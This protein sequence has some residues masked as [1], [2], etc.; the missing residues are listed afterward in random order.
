MLHIS[1]DWQIEVKDIEM[2]STNDAVRWTAVEWWMGE[3]TARNFT[4]NRYGEGVWMWSES[5]RDWK[6]ISGTAQFSL[7]KRDT[8]LKNRRAAVKRRIEK[9]YIG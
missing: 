6:Q 3:P 2:D 9:W 1:D 4:T 8:K 5:G 7:P